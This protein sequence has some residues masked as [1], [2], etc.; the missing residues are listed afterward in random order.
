MR[1]MVAGLTALTFV[2]GAPAPNAFAAVNTF[3]LVIGVDDYQYISPK[4]EGSVNDAT[5]VANALQKDG[6]QDVRLLLD[7]KASRDA[8]MGAWNDLM[9]K[10]QKG[11]NL[12]FHFAGHGGQEPEHVKGSE[13]SGYDSTLLL[14]GFSLKGPGTYERIV[15]DELGAMFQ[16]ASDAGVNLL[17]AIDA[18]HSGTMT[19]AFNNPSIAKPR[20]RAVTYL[21]IA[22]SEDRLPLIDPAWSK[23]P[24][25]LPHVFYFGAVHD[26]EEAPEI[27]IGGQQRG[28]LSWSLASGLRG[29]ADANKDGVITVSELRDYIIDQIQIKV[30]G[31]QHPSIIPTKSRGVTFVDRGEFSILSP[32]ALE[33]VKVAS[34][35]GLTDYAKQL[36]AQAVKEGPGDSGTDK[37]QAIM[38][39][40]QEKAKSNAQQI[41]STAI[42]MA[43]INTSLGAMPELRAPLTNV[44]IVEPASRPLLTWDVGK[45]RVL[46][47]LGDIV[48]DFSSSASTTADDTRAFKRQVNTSE[49]KQTIGAATDV[50]MAQAVIDKW[51]LT[52]LIKTLAEKQSL[53]ISLQPGD[54]IHTLGEKVMF[55]VEGQNQPYLTLFNLASDG[56]VNFIYPLATAEV[57]DPLNIPLG[58]PYDVPLVVAPPYGADHL[59]AIA[60][61]EPLVELHKTLTEIDNKPTARALET[62][63]RTQLNGRTYQIGIHGSYTAKQR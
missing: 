40:I 55:S 14:A 33:I 56:T 29:A 26:H 48:A 50:P 28:A 16:R 34:K 23:I 54:A 63:L 2:A 13:E 47:S 31:Q 18:C 30:E 42:Q 45:R 12:I 43:I 61:A 59:V 4:L 20:V 5:D 49:S 39:A 36:L 57:K 52:E 3:G 58:R 19:R 24:K 21:P 9:A 7:Q 35:D 27:A 10:V 41:P 6:A 60:S 37:L 51:H 32:Q 22:A 44:Q 38:K 46:S 11:D 1:W 62:A 17:V 8:I 15:D 25:E 53:G